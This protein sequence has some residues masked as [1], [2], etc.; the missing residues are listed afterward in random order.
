MITLILKSNLQIITVTG[1]KKY[2]SQMSRNRKYNLKR[3]P[4]IIL[5][6]FGINIIKDL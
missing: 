2:K 3:I 4:F 5:K 1:Y 6:I